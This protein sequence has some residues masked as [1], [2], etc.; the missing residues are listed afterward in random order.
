MIH[1]LLY[2]YSGFCQLER[3]NKNTLDLSKKK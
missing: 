1:F 2:T 3:G